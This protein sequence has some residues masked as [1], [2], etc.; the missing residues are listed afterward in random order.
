MEFFFN[1][2]RLIRLQT[3]QVGKAITV[4]LRSETYQ[5]R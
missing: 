4:H 2:L 3:T 5:N 1:G